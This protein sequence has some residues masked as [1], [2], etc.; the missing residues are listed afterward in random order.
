MLSTILI[1]LLIVLLIG[2][3]P[4]GPTVQVGG[5]RQAV[6]LARSLGRCDLALLGKI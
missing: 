5:T 6:C 4:V 2:A 1:V 3:L